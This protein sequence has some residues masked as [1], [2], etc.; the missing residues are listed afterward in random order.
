MDIVFILSNWKRRLSLE[1][2]QWINFVYYR[3][4]EENKM[5]KLILRIKES[6]FPFRIFIFLSENFWW[7]KFLIKLLDNI[8]WIFLLMSFDFHC[9]SLEIGLNRHSYRV[10]IEN[11]KSYFLLE[12]ILIWGKCFVSKCHFKIVT[13]SNWW[14]R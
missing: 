2:N 8:N 4:F 14:S 6:E 9:Y 12:I 5:S 7:E 1:I 3:Y 13:Y 10:R 11:M